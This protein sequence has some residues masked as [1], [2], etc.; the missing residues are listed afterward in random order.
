MSFC[1]QNS[2]SADEMLQD[3]RTA[4]STGRTAESG[5]WVERQLRAVR[6]NSRQ[7]VFRRSRMEKNDFDELMSI[8]VDIGKDSH[9]AP[10]NSLTYS[11]AV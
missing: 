10:P 7:P 6:D 1:P 2:V 11:Q 3:A 9:P 8:G 5:A 4:A